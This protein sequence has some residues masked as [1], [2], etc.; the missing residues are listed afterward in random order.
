MI[1]LKFETHGKKTGLHI[2]K[3]RVFTKHTNGTITAN[4]KANL[5]SARHSRVSCPRMPYPWNGP[6]GD[7][8]PEIAPWESA[9]RPA[10]PGLFPPFALI[11]IPV[12][13]FSNTI[14]TTQPQ[15]GDM[16]V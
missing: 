6:E 2:L 4:Y 15:R 14:D 12:I 8:A 11:G 5:L 13:R 1:C 9:H 10:A 3:L 16:P 7:P